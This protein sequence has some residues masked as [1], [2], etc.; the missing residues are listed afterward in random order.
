MKQNDDHIQVDL[1]RRDLL[2]IIGTTMIVGPT[3]LHAG[4]A[5]GANGSLPRCIVTPQQ[6]EGPYFVDDRLL[7]ADLRAD[8]SSG[9]ISAGIPLN[10]SLHILAV[11]NRGCNPL[12]GAIVDIWHCDAAG[13]YSDVSDPGFSTIGKKFLRGYQVTNQDGDVRFTTIYPGWYPG[14]AIHIHFKVRPAAKTGPQVEFTS[15]LYFDDAVSEQ[16]LTHPAY[17]GRTGRRLR[18]KQD[19]IFRDGGQQLLLAPRKD[20]T[21]YS[22]SFDIGMAMG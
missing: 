11:S 15:Q 8:P 19:Q 18:N 14:R 16:V 6:T 7:R 3:A 21:G 20:K 4:T 9:A 13:V 12:A 1:N 17:A 10:L 5:S 2:S 22:A